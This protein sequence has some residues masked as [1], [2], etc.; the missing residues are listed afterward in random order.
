MSI[1]R[2]ARVKAFQT[3]VGEGFGLNEDICLIIKQDTL[4]N[5]E[6]LEKLHN[7]IDTVLLGRV[8]PT[9]YGRIRE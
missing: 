5:T 7:Y 4:R 3:I 6:T 1:T 2:E 8:I 9:K